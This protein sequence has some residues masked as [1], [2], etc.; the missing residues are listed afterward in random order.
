[1]DVLPLRVE[2]FVVAELRAP[3]GG[4]GSKTSQVRR[5]Q[6]IQAQLAAQRFIETLRVL[7]ARAKPIDADRSA[8]VSPIDSGRVARY[9][10][11]YKIGN[12]A[13]DIRSHGQGRAFPRGNVSPSLIR[14]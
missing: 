11:G 6:S 13:P 14:N 9:S 12:R 1:M 3:S 7:C 5:Q 10:L 8:R 4:T 2:Q